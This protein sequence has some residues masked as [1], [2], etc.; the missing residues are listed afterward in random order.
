MFAFFIEIRNYKAPGNPELPY[1]S[2]KIN[3]R[4]IMHKDEIE[5]QGD[6]VCISELSDKGYISS[7]VTLPKKWFGYMEAIAYELPPTREIAGIPYSTWLGLDNVRGQ[8]TNK[9]M[10][11]LVADGYFPKTVATIAQTSSVVTIMLKST[12]VTK[13]ESITIIVLDSLRSMMYKVLVTEC[14]EFLKVCKNVNHLD[15]FF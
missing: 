2:V 9:N 1:D 15:D 14:D 5:Q 7:T 4:V 10:F 11:E 6:V 12:L 8:W 13:K 3:K